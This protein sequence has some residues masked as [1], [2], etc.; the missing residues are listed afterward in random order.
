MFGPSFVKHNLHITK[1]AYNRQGKARTVSLQAVS[2][3]VPGYTANGILYNIT[4]Y[5][6]RSDHAGLRL[7]D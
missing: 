5:P 3:A 7:T 2:P 6:S 4:Q 1:I